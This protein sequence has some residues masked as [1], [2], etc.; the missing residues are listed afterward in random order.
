MNQKTKKYSST[1]EVLI[2]NKNNA[3]VHVLF[4]IQYIDE[5]CLDL[6]IEN[7]PI[8]EFETGDAV[9]LTITG[10]G[11][12]VNLSAPGKITK[13]SIQGNGLFLSVAFTNPISLPESLLAQSL[14]V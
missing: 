13:K 1:P 12:E 3:A 7:R 6:K 2:S 8:T 9:F 11:S 14:A 5:T 4:Q 10:I